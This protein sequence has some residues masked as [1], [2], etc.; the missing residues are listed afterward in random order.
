M[1]F[2]MY[3][4]PE[5]YVFTN[6]PVFLS[7]GF[8]LIV[9][10]KTDSKEGNKDNKEWKK[11]LL[12]LSKSSYTLNVMAPPLSAVNETLGKNNELILSALS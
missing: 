10:E 2:L 1:A 11:S 4:G 9:V 7:K 6:H 12:L 8:H 5:Y 3:V